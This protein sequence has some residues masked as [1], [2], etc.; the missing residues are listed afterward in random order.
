MS[1]EAQQNLPGVF[2]ISISVS[3]PS[4][5]ASSHQLE[6]ASPSFPPSPR[7]LSAYARSGPG[8]IFRGGPPQAGRRRRRSGRPCDR[9]Q[10][11]T[12]PRKAVWSVAVGRSA[13][14]PPPARGKWDTH[15]RVKPRGGDRPF[16]PFIL[17]QG[18]DRT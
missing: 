11:Q 12:A 1:Q 14:R 4:A 18:F 16:C 5:H 7:R 15:D 9:N 8:E 13:G 17:P 2:V 6:K 10:R 3:D